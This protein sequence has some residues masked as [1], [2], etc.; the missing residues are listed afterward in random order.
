MFTFFKE[1][2]GES[3]NSWE[4]DKRTYVIAN[5][6]NNYQTIYLRYSSVSDDSKNL[7]NKA[8]R[9]FLL[10]TL[11]KKRFQALSFGPE[12]VL[13]CLRFPSLT[14]LGMLTSTMIS[15]E[16]A[17]SMRYF[18]N[19]VKH[20]MHVDLCFKEHIATIPSMI[21]F[22]FWEK[23]EDTGFYDFITII[24]ALSDWYK[25]ES[26]DAILSGSDV[27]GYENALCKSVGFAAVTPNTCW[28]EL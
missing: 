8:I 27:T 26:G 7:T 20:S 25:L 21:Y 11:L 15:N 1:A 2:N 17:G 23:E 18:N 22:A 6:N 5:M 4:V 10:S 12:L 16:C 3:L 13:L 14:L 19:S 9:M 28:N 24:S